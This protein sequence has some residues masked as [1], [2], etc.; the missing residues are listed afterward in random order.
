MI[1][2]FSHKATHDV[3]SE[4]LKRWSKSDTFTSAA[5]KLVVIRR[6]FLP[7][8]AVFFKKYVRSTIDECHLTQIY[9]ETVKVTKTGGLLF[10]S[11]SVSGARKKCK[12]TLKRKE[13]MRKHAKTQRLQKSKEF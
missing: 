4:C 7:T 9:A 5:I 6:F 12:N 10:P 3:V 1:S 2:L 8:V 13:K 11:R